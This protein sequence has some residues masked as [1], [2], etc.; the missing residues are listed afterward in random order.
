VQE[1]VPELSLV[2]EQELS[3]VLE[4]RLSSVAR[5]LIQTMMTDSTS[6]YS[7]PFWVVA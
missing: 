6:A 4:R 1:L 5:V 7:L 2:L 3:L